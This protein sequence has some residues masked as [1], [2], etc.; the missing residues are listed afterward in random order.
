MMIY[1]F[2]AK[3]EAGHGILDCQIF[4]AARSGDPEAFGILFEQNK[5]TVYSF[6]LQSVGNPDE[7]ED[8]VQQTFVRAWQAIGG[9]RGDSKLLTWLCRIAANLC[10]DHARF[11]KRREFA[12]NKSELEAD[13]TGL[14]IQPIDSIGCK[15]IIRQAIENALDRLPSSHRML[16]VLCDM[17]GFSSKEAA[18]VIGCSPISARVRLSRA[19]KEL[20]RLLAPILDEEVD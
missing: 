1:T 17:E 19:H 7:A 4:A 18:R 6:V 9:F 10:K 11:S 15:Y 2:E 14:H 20:R 12:A 3:T 8:I 16:V 5:N 13:D